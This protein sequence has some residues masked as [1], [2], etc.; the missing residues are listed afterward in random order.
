M[1]GVYKLP[2]EL[3]FGCGASRHTGEKLK[4]LGASK[5]FVVCDPGVKQAGLLKGITTSL[6][7]AGLEFTVYEDIKPEPT[8]DII[9]VGTEYLRKSG[10]D[11]VLGV[12][13]GSALDCAKA[14]AAMV[15]N[16]G[17]IT[18]YTGVGKLKNNPLPVVA[19]PTTAGT[20][21]EITMFTVI[22]DAQ[23]KMKAPVGSY[24]LMPVLAILDPELTVGLP[25]HLTAS[26][27]MD[28][29]THAVESYVNVNSHYISEALALQAI[30]LIARSLRKAV[31][32]GT[33]LQA[34]ED[35]LM[36]STIAALAFNSTR[37]GLV[38]AM[39]QPAGAHFGIP[40][41]LSNAI[42]LPHVM[43]YNLMGNPEK[44]A[45]IAALFG[46]PTGGLPV[47]EAAARSVKAVKELMADIGIVEGL[48]AFGVREEHLGMLA[49]EALTSGNVPL[50]PRQPSKGD[51]IEIYKKAL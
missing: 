36:A 7:E 38:H 28:A 32:R 6:K 37:L 10:C 13:G 51:I 9:E 30:K 43:E 18:D 1:L 47:M 19:V 23:T 41:G 21:S 44:F 45:E 3:F 29:L 25:P 31:A 33:N 12:G 34:R 4:E 40:H 16:E 8:S 26:T 46:E 39:S 50:N 49:D 17:R 42:L 35:M 48:G 11:V 5:V 2:T 22:T 15:T 24:M 27:G 20:G 14:F